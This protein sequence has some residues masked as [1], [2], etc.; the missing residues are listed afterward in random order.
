MF[1]GKLNNFQHALKTSNRC[2]NF[3]LSAVYTQELKNRIQNDRL[4][5]KYYDIIDIL[6][7]P[8]AREEFFIELFHYS[9]R[10]I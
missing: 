8:T 9:L 7:K 3:F 6:E 4:V 1:R 5:E 2:K 10:L